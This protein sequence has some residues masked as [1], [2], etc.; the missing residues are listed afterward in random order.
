MNKF[1]KVLTGLVVAGGVSCL[2]G[3]AA[4]SESA[5]KY[6]TLTFS[7]GGL[8]YVMQGALAEFDGNNEAFLS[9]GTV[10]DGVEV[11]FTLS[12]GANSTGTPQ[13]TANGETLTPDADGVY[14]FIMKSDTKVEASGLNTMYN[15]TLARYEQFVE[16]GQ[17][18]RSERWITYLDENGNEFSKDVIVDGDSISDVLRVESGKPFK[19]KLNVSPYYV[20]KYTVS[21]DTEVLDPDA[22]GV[23]TIDNIKADTTVSVSG[24][25]M[26][27]SFI[28]GR[29]DCGTGTADD[30]FLLSKPVDLFYFAYIV[31]S[32]Y[33]MEFKNFNYKLAADI[34]MRGERLFV[35]GDYSNESA[36]FTGRFDGNGKKISNFYITDEVVDQSSFEKAYLP[37][38][39]LFG[40]ASADLNQGSAEIK[41]LTLENYE[42][43][44]HAGA[45]EQIT[46]AGSV[47]GYGVGV[48]I[49]NCHVTGGKFNG[50]T[51][52]II[53]TNDNN[54]IMI[55]G[56]VAGRLQAG[57]YNDGTR[58][59][60][61]DAFVRAS[62]SDVLVD[63]TGSPRSAGGIVGYLMSANVN[64]IAYV[65]NCASAADVSGAM[66]SG[67]IVG[68][69]GMYSSVSNC[70]S[71]SGVNSNNAISADMIDAYY[72]CSYAGGIVGFAEENSVISGCYAANKYLSTNGNSTY[73]KKTGEIYGHCDVAG[74]SATGSQSV[75]DINNSKAVEGNPSSVFINTLGW[76][77][78]DWDFTG[79]LPQPKALPF[80]GGRVIK[81]TVLDGNSDSLVPLH[82]AEKT[83]T[84][85]A[86]VYTWY[87]SGLLPEYL[88][89]E[90]TLRSWGYYFDKELTRKVPQ[91]YIPAGDVALYAGYADYSEAAGTYH[92]VPTARANNAFIVLNADGTYLLRNG[93]LRHTGTY[94][95]DG[96]K[97][98][99]LDTALASLSRDSDATGGYYFAFEGKVTG[100]SSLALNGK[101]T[102]ITVTVTGVDENGQQITN[103]EY[104]N[105]SLSFTAFK[106]DVNFKYG[107][108]L[109][110]DGVNYTFEK[111]GTGEFVER[112]VSY[113]FLYVKTDTEITI[114]PSSGGRITGVVD[115]GEVRSVMGL[116]NN[117]ALVQIPLSYRDEFYGEWK[118]S[119]NA[120]VY[121]NFDGLGHVTCYDGKN[122]AATVEYVANPDG[123]GV[124]FNWNGDDYNYKAS[125]ND[126]GELIINNETYFFADGFTG[127]WFLPAT[128]G[129][130]E[131]I[132]IT[133]YGIGKNGF[134]N[135]V[136]TYTG[137]VN[138]SINAQ[139][140]V[141]KSGNSVKLRLFAD[142]EQYGE[143]SYDSQH[144]K[145]TGRMYSVLEASYFTNAE[146]N[147]Y[148]AFKGTWVSNA[149]DIDTI[150]FNGRTALGSADVTLRTVGGRTRY[151]TYTVTGANSGTVTITVNG[152]TKTYNLAFD[153][154]A[155]KVVLT[156][157]ETADIELAQRDS[158]YRAVLNGGG[159]TYTF[160]GK[161]L[162]GG[163]VEVSDGTTLDYTIVNGTVT[164]GE[165]ELVPTESGFDWNG[166]VLSFN[167]GFAGSWL[168]GGTQEKLTI[169]EVGGGFTA[170]VTYS[171]DAG[172]YEF[173]YNPSSGVLTYTQ[174]VN[175]V[176]LVT[177]ISLLGDNALSINRNGEV[178]G[179]KDGQQDDW[180]GTFTAEDGSSWT[181]DGLGA[182]S[183]GS[184]T[185]TYTEGG[186]S[187]K[188][189]YKVDVKGVVNIRTSA[190]LLFVE[191]ESGESGYTNG[192][193]TYKTVTHDF[194]YGRRVFTE[195]DNVKTWYYFDGRSILWKET[196]SGYEA[197]YTYKITSAYGVELTATA[198]GKVYVAKM[199]EEG[200][201]FGMTL[202][203]KE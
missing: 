173:V 13:I 189:K 63:G 80:D 147:L 151:G 42:L 193:K 85:A 154:L 136:I 135:A 201:Y 140:D 28:T 84:S 3:A 51:G 190:G 6:Y 187:V 184:G 116:D 103:T 164:L 74:A 7:G 12:L 54:Q 33:Y 177:S 176:R 20:P 118:K 194:L 145:I 138:V 137:A 150:T 27:E 98:M 181:F 22:N 186:V 183:Y 198:T 17:P 157:D 134:G 106:E 81:I 14:S 174:D 195:K 111:N 200:I 77:A 141:F 50:K 158:W 96:N 24:L 31:N 168:V 124:I 11:R 35:I 170:K 114:S 100:G 109:A 132:S 26:E 58:T 32:D 40:Y 72:R 129:R 71:V 66:H 43:R 89:G 39:G 196:E 115:N 162:V 121:F 153:E 117:G 93:G 108:Y 90:G 146:F 34:D 10:K 61:F 97:L 76:P 57:Y 37:Y 41:N 82:E 95:Y 179:L 16:N 127:S 29:K 199:T 23:Y 46:L 175:G 188:Y 64:A 68:T 1:R 55:L 143:L 30:P 70:Y 18:V 88:N 107:T 19:F 192:G 165:Y 148:D 178:K 128:A 69:L 38:V 149:E 78:S 8:D 102:I 161:G 139:Y 156:A 36:I 180:R 191:A 142:D 171:G 101:V 131:F 15:L 185:A 123:N 5:P 99:L 167:T 79:A 163:K 112:G 59:L 44:V 130:E 94:T 182:C 110:S 65:M 62:T 166:T 4:C 126:E 155:N 86:P 73:S 119:A 49:S 92:L 21:C 91:G 160:N 169:A 67:G 47:L 113:S 53:A 48:E 122:P 197:T 133:L 104:S 75:S 2:A 45:E 120:L 56:G 144:E 60:T 52:G 203:E 159:K 125:F 25:D 105:E 152:E 87:E 83:V 172:E 9:G 202:T